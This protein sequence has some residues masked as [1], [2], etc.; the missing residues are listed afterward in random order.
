V[1]IILEDLLRSPPSP[2][3][4]HHEFDGDASTLDHRLADAR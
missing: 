4:I 2:N 3:K 1:V